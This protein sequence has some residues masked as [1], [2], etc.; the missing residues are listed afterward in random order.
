M[1]FVG[2]VHAATLVI[3]AVLDTNVLISTLLFSGLP[4]R[5]VTAWQFVQF[6]PVVSHSILDE[7]LEYLCALA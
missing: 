6:Q 1:R 4:S 3:R 2:P 5:L 7:Y